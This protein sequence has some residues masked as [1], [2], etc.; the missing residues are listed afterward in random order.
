[1]SSLKNSP[2]PLHIA[3]SLYR[4]RWSSVLPY[5]LL[6]VSFYSLISFIDFYIPTRWLA[7]YYQGASCL[8]ILLVPLM[9]GFFNLLDNR[10]PSA[11]SYGQLFHQLWQK[12]L[13]IFGCLI[14][15]C[16]LPGLLFIAFLI[17]SFL[18]IRYGHI[19]AP[20]FFIW[21]GFAGL[22][23]FAAIVPKLLAFSLIFTDNLNANEA[24]DQSEALTKCHFFSSLIYSLFAVLLISFIIHLPSL[25]PYYLGNVVPLIW[26]Q[27]I[28]GVLLVVVGPW[29]FA[30]ILGYQFY[31]QDKSKATV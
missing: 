1:M 29:C 8:I 13:T 27:L 25:I 26:L 17:L 31:L 11:L 28:S 3:C 6:L 12:V 30:L 24:I 9:T 20:L 10:S 21:M 22:G 5:S 18:L 14:S 16:V 7:Y 19:S 4:N 15:L 2:S 23:I